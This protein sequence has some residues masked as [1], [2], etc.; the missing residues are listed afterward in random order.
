MNNFKEYAN[1]FQA[2]SNLKLDGVRRLAEKVGNPQ[3]KLKFIHV[4]GT[5]GKGSVCAFLQSILTMAG[6]KTGKFISP[7]MLDVCERISVD[8]VNISES[9]MDA[10]MQRL[11]EASRSVHEE[12]G[13]LPTQFEIWTVAAFMYFAE[14]RCGAVV[15][16]TGLGGRMDATNII[17]KPLF[18]IITRIDM[19]HM[20][21]LGNTIERIAAEKCG[22]IKESCPVITL[23]DERVAD[24]IEKAANDMH[25][26]LIIAK[27]AQSRGFSDMSELF[28]YGNI[29]GIKCG[30]PGVHQ[31]ENAS[32]AIE[33][34][35]QMGID[36]KIIAC[37]I[38]NASN[39]GR[40]ERISENPT[41]IFDGAHNGSGIDTLACA[42]RRYFPDRDVSF[43]FGAMADK[44]LNPTMQSFKNHGFGKSR[45]YTVAV[46]DNPRA[47]SQYALADSF[48]A[49]GFS[50]QPCKNIGEAYEK[51]ASENGVTVICG[52][53][54]LYKDLADY[55]KNK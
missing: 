37:G 18:S 23:S 25:S 4:A 7:N 29:H 20:N 21:Y 45:F 27:K 38:E 48:A 46:E 30:L 36:E 13:K 10:L 42:I 2:V 1:S 22:I 41:V 35:L 12:T 49:N 51:A 44:D 34:A 16:E 40:L 32:L 19:D 9:E 50:A 17:E 8:G 26:R 53:L 14:K 54:Y 33:C 3:K 6:I 52:S 31:I 15:L 47:A 43:I 5:N 55:L 39:P 28:D 11:S 24:V